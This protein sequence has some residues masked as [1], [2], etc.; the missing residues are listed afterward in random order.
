MRGCSLSCP[1]LAELPQHV[2]SVSLRGFFGERRQ[3][4]RSGLEQLLDVIRLLVDKGAEHHSLGEFPRIRVLEELW[5]I[6]GAED[7]HP[8]VTPRL[9]GL[10]R[11]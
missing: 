10:D 6:G 1:N 9:A 5:V 8:E 11:L 4:R 7:L 3:L 2:L